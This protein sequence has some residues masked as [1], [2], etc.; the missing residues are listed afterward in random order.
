MADKRNPTKRTE[1]RSGR[2]SADGPPDLPEGAERAEYLDSE[3][4]EG[5]AD[6]T[7]GR[8]GAEADREADRKPGGNPDE[9]VRDG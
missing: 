2:D 5:S 4:E 9:S 7:R 3:Q 1:E 6:D 8:G